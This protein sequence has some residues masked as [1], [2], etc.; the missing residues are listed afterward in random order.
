MKLIA[1]ILTLTLMLSSL[2]ANQIKTCEFKTEAH[3][4]EYTYIC[5]ANSLFVMV[6]SYRYLHQSI[7]T[8]PLYQTCEC[9]S[10]GQILLYD[11]LKEF[12]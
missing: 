1:M 3:H 6:L 5:A 7:S 8:L 12:E 4:K 2:T 10:K 9:D 11:D